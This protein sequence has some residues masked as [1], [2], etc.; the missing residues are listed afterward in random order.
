MRSSTSARLDVRARVGRTVAVAALVVTIAA[1]CTS[2]PERRDL[3]D[4]DI[5]A[6]PTTAATSAGPAPTVASDVAGLSGRLA[7]LDADGHL[8]TMDP[9]GSDEIMLDEVEPGT[10]QVRQPTWSPDGRS[11]AWVHLEV[12]EA[13]ALSA[14]VAT[15]RDGGTRPTMARTAIV[16]FYLS[17]D[18]TSSRI[19]LPRVAGRRRIALGILEVMG[20][21]AGTSLDTGQPVLPLV[22]AG[23]RPA[24]RPRRRGPARSARSRR[25]ADDGRRPTGDLLGAGVD[26]R[27]TD[28]RL[29][30][31]GRGRPAA[32][33]SRRRGREGTD[34]RPV[35][36]VDRLRRQPGRQAG[37]VPGAR[38]RAN[39]PALGDRRSERRDRRD[40]RLPDR[41]VLLEPRRRAPAL[42]G[43]GPAPRRHGALVPLGRVGRHVLVRHAARRP[44]PTDS[45]S[46]TCSS[47]SS[48]RR[49][50]ACGRRTPARSPIRG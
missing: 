2:Q 25:V 15:S 24:A 26:R 22:G 19:G 32:R 36:R 46:S 30:G 43:T 5:P 38:T 28:V 29:R 48:T 33:R 44:E 17:W 1:S 16:P 4:V 50:C 3:P 20:R 23:R 34:A 14:A 10:S 8:V 40:R 39:A 35:R 18:P 41:V 47:S 6:D 42:P 27:W 37:R 13:G 31:G 21:S 9:D 12:T 7:V 11:V 45:R 49:A